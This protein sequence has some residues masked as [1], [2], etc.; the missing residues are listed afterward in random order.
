VLTS[1]EAG[2]R[3]SSASSGGAVQC[4]EIRMSPAGVEVRDSKD[5]EPSLCF[6]AGSWRTFIDQVGEPGCRREEPS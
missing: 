4:V 2:W 6:R 1:S 3:K 5:V